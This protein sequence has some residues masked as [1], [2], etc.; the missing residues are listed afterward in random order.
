MSNFSDEFFKPKEVVEQAE[1]PMRGNYG[2]DPQYK[3]LYVV[4]AGE[5]HE[6]SFRLLI[7]TTNKDEAFS[8]KES[9]D[10]AVR[11]YDAALESLRE[12]SLLDST[13][14][15]N[16][17]E[18]LKRKLASIGVDHALEE[19]DSDYLYFEVQEVTAKVN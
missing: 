10:Y 12:L 6:P 8:I 7:A 5:S 16:L 4:I 3:K 17:A 19:I 15:S 9:A 11:Q 18:L 14:H 13:M 1:P 2:P